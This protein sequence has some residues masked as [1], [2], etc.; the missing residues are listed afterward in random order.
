MKNFIETLQFKLGGWFFSVVVATIFAVFGTPAW[1]YLGLGRP[2][3][4]FWLVI[5]TIILFSI[6]GVIAFFLLIYQFTTNSD[7]SKAPWFI[8]LFG[9]W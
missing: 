5:I 1:I 4:K 2:D 6:V 9:K 7:I 8:K 3:D